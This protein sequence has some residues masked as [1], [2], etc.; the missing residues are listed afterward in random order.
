MKQQVSPKKKESTNKRPQQP[1]SPVVNATHPGHHKNALQR[2]VLC[3]DLV[4]LGRKNCS[5]K[6]FLHQPKMY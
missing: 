3:P 4:H 1:E 2:L 6:G 5:L